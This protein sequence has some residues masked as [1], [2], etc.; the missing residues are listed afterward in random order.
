MSRFFAKGFRLVS[1]LLAVSATIYAQVQPQELSLIPKPVSLRVQAG[2]FTL[3][4][5]TIIITDQWTLPVG[6]LLAGML[7]PAT[8]YALKV[9]QTKAVLNNSI[10]LRIDASLSRLGDEGY[11]LEVTPLRVTIRAP[12]AAGAFYATQTLRQLFPPA[13]YSKMVQKG[14]TWSTPCVQIEDHPRFIWR[15]AMMDVSRHFMPKEFVLKFIDLLAMHKL[16]VFHWHL[17]DDQGWRI[18]IKKYPKL[19]QIGAWRK[20]TRLGH[21]R[22]QRGFDGK[23]H[24]G[25][26][27]QAEI[28]EVVRYAA[29]RFV[30]VVPEIEMPGHAQAAIAAYPKLGNTGEK[31]EV[32]TR[33]GIHQNIF[34]ANEKTV[35]F[36]QDVLKEVLRLF[37]SKFI[38]IGGDEAVKDQWKVSQQAQARIKEL[39]LKDEH[40]LQSYF[41]R[42]MDEFLTARGRRLIGWDEILEGGLAPGA[43][44]M[45]WRGTQGGITAAQAGHDVVMAP[46]THTYLDY[47]QANP[48]VEPLAI[49]GFLPLEKVYEFEPIPVELS[50]EEARRV[51]GAQCQLWTEYIPTPSHLEYMAFPRLL[52]LAEVTWTPKE[53]KNYADFLNRLEAQQQ[54]LRAL[55]VNFRPIDQK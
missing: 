48:E 30:T 20:E 24:G 15:G 42:R 29:Q 41:I 11:R 6:K 1:I 14:F 36:L 49:G 7:A 8:G 16:N 32:S 10:I 21:E 50:S 27:T 33:W 47:Y 26:Y 9:R 51:L 46:T 25:F 53:Q 18:E 52:A 39:G 43:T 37:P 4:P 31:L 54:R 55:E 13:I 44:V 34:N 35:R 40:E 17:T 5:D 22:E 2:T 12:K 23:P 38:H 3:K 45:S 28:R 19:T